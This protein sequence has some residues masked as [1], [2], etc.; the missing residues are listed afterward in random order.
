MAS[1]FKHWADVN[2]DIKLGLGSPAFAEQKKPPK[3]KL[4]WNIQAERI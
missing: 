3:K 2:I 4:K 1:E